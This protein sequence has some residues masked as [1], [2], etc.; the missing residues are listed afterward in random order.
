MVLTPAEEMVTL[1]EPS[2]CMLCHAIGG[3]PEHRK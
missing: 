2:E 1:E 3:L